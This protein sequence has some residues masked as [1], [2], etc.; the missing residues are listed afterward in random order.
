MTLRTPCR[1]KPLRRSSLIDRDFGEVLHGIQAAMAHAF[2]LDH[3]ALVPPLELAGGD[4]GH[5]DYVL[6]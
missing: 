2:G 1:E 3:A 5:G 4:S 6:R